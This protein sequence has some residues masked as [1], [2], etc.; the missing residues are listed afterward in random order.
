MPSY[1]SA[2]FYQ[3]WR[4]AVGKEFTTRDGQPF[5]YAENGHLHW[6]DEVKKIEF[7]THGPYNACVS[8]DGRSLAVALEN[9]IHIID[10]N[11]GAIVCILRGHAETPEGFAFAPNDSNILVST[12]EHDFGEGGADTQPVVIVW[13]IKE[14]QQRRVAIQSQASVDEVVAEAA[15]TATSKLVEKGVKDSEDLRQRL[16]K[17]IKPGVT[18]VVASELVKDTLHLRGRIRTSF[19]AQVFSPSG[20]RLVYI[21]GGHLRSNDVDV[22]DINIVSTSNFQSDRITLHGHTDSL[23]WMGWN[24]DES[25]FAS[26]CWDQ[27]I[28]I[29]DAN[30]GDQRFCFTTTKQNWAGGFSPDSKY[31][32]ATCGTGATHIFDLSDGSTVW[33]FE[34]EGTRGWRRTLDWHPNSKW[35]AVGGESLAPVYVL[36]VEKKEVLQQRK[37]SPE[38]SQAPPDRDIESVRSMIGTFVGVRQVRFID[39]GNKLAVWTSGDDSIEVYDLIRQVKWRFARGGTDGD[40][41]NTKWIDGR[42]QIKSTTG[43]KMLIWEDK[44]KG[45]TILASVDYDGIRLWPL[46]LTAP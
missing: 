4:Y 19:G 2:Q 9:D 11:T 28:R 13:N 21:P 3:D 30:T 14:Y 32:A 8:N 31:F 16:E 27:T 12:A 44:E 10:T 41:D 34:R 35:L 39:G 37:L 40:F 24:P 42:G 20:K 38:K 6:D 26:V 5:P 7:G 46:A 25:L 1:S 43:C 23:M 15:K 18:S 33:V 36:D 22:W 17:A 29:W 45:Q